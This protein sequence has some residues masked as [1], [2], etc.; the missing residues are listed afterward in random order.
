MVA[1]R[2]RRRPHPFVGGAAD[3]GASEDDRR[4]GLRVRPVDRSDLRPGVRQDTPIPSIQLCIEDVGSLSA[5]AATATAACIR[6]PSRGPPRRHRCLRSA[7]RAS[8]S[9][10][11]SAPG[12]QPRSAP[13]A[14]RR[15]A[16]SS[17]GSRR[18]RPA[19][20]DLGAGDRGRS[21]AIWRTSG[22]RAADRQDR[23]PQRRAPAERQLPD[24]P[25]ACRT[26]SASTS[27]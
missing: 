7:S 26:R 16:A 25:S 15:I 12:P 2:G 27:T 5:A 14:D 21:T 23:G 6:T 10:G 11:C 8:C 22:D 4:C 1:Q 18:G 9:S 24:A 20:Q 13:R 19:A 3:R 17:T